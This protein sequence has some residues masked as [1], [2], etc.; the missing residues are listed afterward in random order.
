MAKKIYYI[1][2]CLPCWI[3]GFSPIGFDE[4]KHF[5][6]CPNCTGNMMLSRHKIGE[7]PNELLFKPEK[8]VKATIRKQ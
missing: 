5:L 1:G 4:T 7:K 3:W 6:V 8:E 2:E